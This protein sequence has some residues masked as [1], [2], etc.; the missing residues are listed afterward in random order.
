[1]K[2]DIAII[3]VVVGVYSLSLVP[4]VIKESGFSGGK[5]ES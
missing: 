4:F 1:M 2:S 5:I 3:P